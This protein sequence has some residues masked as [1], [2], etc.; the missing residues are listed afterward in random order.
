VTP[1]DDKEMVLV[2]EPSDDS[3]AAGEDNMLKRCS[4]GPGVHCPNCTK[5]PKLVPK[6][7]YCPLHPPSGSCIQCIEWRRSLMP[8]LHQQTKR[9]CKGVRMEV[10]P[11]P[12]PER[13]TRVPAG[14]AFQQGVYQ[15]R[16]QMQRI[17]FCFGTENADKTVTIE[18]IYGLCGKGYP[19][20]LIVRAPTVFSLACSRAFPVAC[21]FFRYPLR[22]LLSNPT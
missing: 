8:K 10:A 16:N 14:A 6:H 19:D 11:N 3:S 15:L 4:H 9:K 13:Y 2:D 20:A 17:G 5:G 1:S 21:W 7:R 12:L 22:P 18:F